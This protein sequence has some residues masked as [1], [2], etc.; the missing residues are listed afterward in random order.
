M[1][2]FG[3]SRLNTMTNRRYVR[4]SL[5]LPR[6]WVCLAARPFNVNMYLTAY[7]LLLLSTL[8]R[9]IEAMGGSLSLVA[10]FPD[11]EPILLSGISGEEKD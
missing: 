9:S 5:M 6:F 1:S 4:F 11:R 8:R 3:R 7:V 10:R 2:E